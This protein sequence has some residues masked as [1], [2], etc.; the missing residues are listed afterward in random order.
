MKL[1]T[2]TETR[3]CTCCQINKSIENFYKHKD[4]YLFRCK[5][6]LSIR[7]KEKRLKNKKPVCHGPE[8]KRICSKCKI[9]KIIPGNFNKHIRQPFG[10]SIWCKNKCLKLIFMFYASKV[11]DIMLVKVIM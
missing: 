6:C 2:D 4:G 9:E 10:I 8:Y 11:V 7:Q 1:N 3:I 5:K